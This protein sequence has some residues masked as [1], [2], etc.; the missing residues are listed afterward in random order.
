MSEAQAALGRIAKESDQ[1]GIAVIF[2]LPLAVDGRIYN[3]AAFVSGGA[4]LDIVPKTC[5]PMTNEYY[6]ERW[7]TSATHVRSSIVQIDGT[8]IP[9][10]TDL[11]FRAANLRDCVI[12]IEICEDL[13]AV[14]PP[15]YWTC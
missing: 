2:G 5:L 1:L 8:E 10:G 9:F 4:I 13:W 3:C 7:F 6:E 11:L 12:G 14:H 15:I